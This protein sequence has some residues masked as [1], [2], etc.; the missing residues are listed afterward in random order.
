MKRVLILIILIFIS[1][2]TAY[3]IYEPKEGPFKVIKII[4][5]DTVDLNNSE[6][7]RLSGIDTPEIGECYYKEAKN[8]LE[9]LILNKDVFLER[10]ISDKGRYGRLLR[11]IYVNNLLINSFLV[12]EGYAKVHDKYDY[13][14]KLYKE[15]KEV[16][17][18]AKNNKLGV[19]GCKNPKDN[20]LYVGS[21]FSKIYH[22]PECKWAKRIKPENLICFKSK[23]EAEDLNYKPAKTC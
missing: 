15:L 7:V 19:W 1:G 23:E 2:C 11:Y 22:K 12:K 13:D 20:C 14:I 21:K 18:T 5:G 17:S 6:R 10:D 3:T 16:E 9:D 8:K 4:D